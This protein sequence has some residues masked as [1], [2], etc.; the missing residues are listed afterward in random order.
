MILPCGE[1][2]IIQDFCQEGA[3]VAI[4][5][6]R[7]VRTKSPLSLTTVYYSSRQGLP[8]HHLGAVTRLG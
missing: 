7:G 8:V 4:V 1:G 5:K 6:L 3:H 2:N